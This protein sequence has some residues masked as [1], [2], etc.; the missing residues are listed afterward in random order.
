MG[1]WTKLA[2]GIQVHQND[3]WRALVESK[4]SA[5]EELSAEIDATG[6]RE[7]YVTVK[8]SEC[9]SLYQAYVDEGRPASFARELAIDEVFSE[10]PE[11]EDYEIDGGLEDEAA[12]FDESIS[13]L[14]HQTE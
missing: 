2:E 3:P 7:A 5:D 13:R 1:Y 12:A 4:L 9:Q 11:T 6:E 8:A 10:D 14:G